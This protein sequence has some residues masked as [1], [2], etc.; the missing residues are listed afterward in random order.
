MKPS[1]QK[2]QTK[3]HKLPTYPDIVYKLEPLLQL[4]I[5]L[6]QVLRWKDDL[7]QHSLLC[8]LSW[9]LLCLHYYLF[10]LTAPLWFIL[11]LHYYD[12]TYKSK[13]KQQTTLLNYERV[14][15]ELRAIQIELDSFL[16]LDW[17]NR[18]SILK[19]KAWLGV[20]TMALWLSCVTVFSLKYCVWFLGLLALSWKSPLFELSRHAC[21]RVM[22]IFQQRTEAAPPSA[23]VHAPMKSNAPATTQSHRFFCFTVIEHQRWY[24]LR[25]WTCALLP[26]DRPEW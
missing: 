16:H 15:T 8:V 23:Y 14:T 7:K 25:G 2:E 5:Y 18:K 12:T 21:H 4:S 20:L 6:L 19:N 11:L 26:K 24:P 13:H 17:F 1:T 10:A 3:Q 22:L 9:T